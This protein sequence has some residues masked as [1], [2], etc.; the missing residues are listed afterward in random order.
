[1]MKQQATLTQAR[2]AKGWSARGAA[3]QTELKKTASSGQAAV[4]TFLAARGAKVRSFWI[5]NALRVEADQATIDALRARSDVDQ[6]LPDRQYSIPPIAKSTAQAVQTVEWGLSSIHAPEAWATFGARGDGIV[7]ANIDTGVQFDHPALQ[8]QYRGTSAPGVFDHNYNWYDP[9]NICGGAPCDNVFHGTH[10]MGTMVG[11]DGDPGENQVG[12]APH[13]RWIAAKGCEFNSCSLESLLAAAEWVLAPTDLSGQNPRPDLRPHI[14]NNSWGGGSGDPFF[15]AAVQSWIAAGMFPTFS[16]GN[17]GPSCGSANSPGDY[18]ESYAVGAY[19]SSNSIAFFSSRGPSAFGLGK[20]NIAAPGVFVRSSVPGNGYDFFDGTSMAAPHV[21]GSVALIW[22]VAPTLVGDI[23]STRALLDQTAVN[24]NDTSCGGTPENNN[25]WG[26]GQLNVFEAV[27]AAP[28]GP[29]GTLSGLVVASAGGAPIAGAR[30]TARMAGIPD[31]STVSGVDGRYSLTV[32]VGT[33]AVTVNLFGYLD[34]TSTATVTE[35]ATTDQGF[36]LTAAPSFTVTGHVSDSLGGALAGA[37]VK[38]LGTPLSPAVTDATGAYSFAAV[39]VGSYQISADAGHCNASQTLPLSVT[40]N[41]V[42]DFALPKL[43]DS[44]GYS[45]SPVSYE[46]IEATHPLTS[47]GDDDQFTV[48]L[49]FQ[50]TY[51]GQTYTSANISINGAV[52]FLSNQFIGFGNTPLPDPTLPNGAIYAFWD[53]LYFDGVGSLS[54]EVIGTAPNRKFVIEWKDVVLLRDTSQRLTFEMV[55]SET[56]Q[57][58]VQYAS[59]GSPGIAGDSATIGIEDETGAVGLQYSYNEPSLVAQS[60]VLYTLPPSGFVT[61]VVT[62]ANDGMPV[63]GASV[64]AMSGATQVRST[65]T[66]EHGAYRLQVPVGTYSVEASLARYTSQKVNVSIA[67][68]ETI[69]RNFA[70]TTGRA[71][72]TP[73]TIQLLLPAGQTRTRTLALKNTGS[74]VL[75]W[76]VAESGGRRQ[77]TVSTL[78]LARNPLADRNARDTRSLFSAPTPPKGWAPNA[79]GDLLASFTPTGTTFAWGVG[80][81]GKVWVSDIVAPGS[82]RNVEFTTEGTPTGAAWPAPWASSFPADMAHDLN[83]N[84]M[85]QLDVGGDN[86]IHCWDPGTGLVTNTIVGSFPWTGTSQRGLAYR[87]DDDTFYVG[88]WNEG[89]IYHVKGLS[90][91]D[92]GAVL[93]TCRPAD[94]S[95]SGLAWNGAMGVLWA[96][97]NSPTDTIYELN[98]S[99]CTALS[100]LAHPSP[101]FNGGGLEM[102]EG[103]NLWMIGQNPNRVYL[104]DSG[105]PAYNDVPW[106]SVTPTSGALLANRTQNITVTVNTAGLTPGIYLATLFVNSDAGRESQIRVPVSLVVSSYMQGVNAGGNAY[107][108]GL[109]DNWLADRAY[110]SGSWGYVQ[111]SKTA[112]TTKAITGT[113]DPTLYKSQR[114]DPYAYRFDNVPNGV[115]QVEFRFAEIQNA[116]LG[117]RLFDVIVEN[118]EVLPA[119]DIRY[120]V[121]TFAAD[122]QTF[123]IPVTDGRMDVRF[124]PRTGFDNPVINALRITH[125]PDR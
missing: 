15:Q 117:K 93:G 68:N 62:D 63:G 94:G 65:L 44:F 66:D 120:E 101:G 103:G 87:P 102:D 24:V 54:T 11:D 112:T 25:V 90:Y 26:E 49:P 31:R 61:G 71:S 41:V 79:A 96:A 99:D 10:T 22:S 122:N 29:T 74:A 109:G 34:S 82:H 21:S 125:R 7:V 45:C 6:V 19:D 72:L 17:S 107:R 91:P 95:I 32:P 123:F 116:K 76:S 80:Y 106:L 3:V 110:T 111:K 115:Y 23:S 88:G 73:P 86:G 78:S 92:K 57:I 113:T 12:V 8:R 118:T 51:Y 97:T 70:L 104:I 30:V 60:A 48:P 13:A 20:P 16:A 46:F 43:K 105:V 2:A 84:L 85:C 53:D 50:F 124:I 42:V 38:I 69:T 47:F 9:A 1:M 108:D 4:S 114:V 98:P 5:V 67:E 119:H 59:G 36:S 121:G 77:S 28:R 52:G 27:N 37:Q 56:G 18:P 33:Y 81:T 14:V 35:G 89:V 75:N 100:T 55:L 83:R 40:A 58:L 64:R 39:P